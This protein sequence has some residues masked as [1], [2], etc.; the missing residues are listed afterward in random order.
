VYDDDE[1]SLRDAET[2]CRCFT[3]L[4][5]SAITTVYSDALLAP[6]GTYTEVSGGASPLQPY[7]F[8]GYLA[9]RGLG[10]DSFARLHGASASSLQGTLV[11]GDR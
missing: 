7:S 2:T 11:S 8:T 3:Q 1:H 4:P 9:V 10:R 5:L 6:R